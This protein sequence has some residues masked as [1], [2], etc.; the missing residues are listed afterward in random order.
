[1]R[2]QFVKHLLM[3]IASV[4]QSGIIVM[5][6]SLNGKNLLFNAVNLG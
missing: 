3:D 6:H 4:G 5:V 2:K 1:M